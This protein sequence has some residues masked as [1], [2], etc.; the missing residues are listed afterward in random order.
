[1]SEG[2]DAREKYLSL[3][4]FAPLS[5]VS[6]KSTKK[7]ARWVLVGA[8]E[9]EYYELPSGGKVNMYCKKGNWGEGKGVEAEEE[10]EADNKNGHVHVA[11]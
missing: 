9:P 1:M 11:A 5:A 10:A 7:D 2:G 8:S 6:F 3:R 4:S